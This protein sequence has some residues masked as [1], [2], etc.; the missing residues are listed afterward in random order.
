MDRNL[1]QQLRQAVQRACEKR[2]PLCIQG[3][4]SKSFYGRTARGEPLRVADHRGI[5]AYEPGELTI[6]VRCGT[7]VKDVES[8]L[9][10]ENQML[11][12]EPPR[13]TDDATMGGILACGFS[14]PRRMHAGSVRDSLLGLSCISGEG[15]TLRLGGAVMK[16]VAGFDAFRLMVGAMGTLAVMLDATFKVLPRSEC[17]D[18]RVFECDADQAIAMMN[19][20]AS[21]PI[22]VSATAW[23]DGRLYARLEG[24]AEAV[25]GA[26]RELGGDGL[27]DASGFWRALRDHRHSWLSRP[28]ML[29]RI[30]LPP[31]TPQLPIVGEWLIEWGGAQRWLRT[32]MA[33]KF[34]R[35]M[36]VRYRGHATVYR[37]GDRDGSVFHP[38]PAPV[39][40]MHRRLKEAFDPRGI[41]NPQRLYREL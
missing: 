14:G 17:H 2:T 36:C 37:G 30:A 41:L 10:S 22:P 39:L 6:T 3:N 26:Q 18:T 1:E 9:A 19:A 40:Q 25:A 38:L 32:A 5:V 20:W 31:A 15:R 16:N 13:H 28:D 33:P 35:E 11:A 23:H 24:T 29:W 12:F 7:R 8:V 4:G 27:D 34:V 21:R